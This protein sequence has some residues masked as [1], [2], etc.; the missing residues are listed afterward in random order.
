MTKRDYYDILG[1]KKGASK[2]EIKKAYRK[3]ALKYHPDKNKSAGAEDK[4]KEISE[5]YGVLSDEQKR[6]QYDRFGHAGI[7]S[8]YTQEDIFKNINFD[9]IFGDL[10]F[11]GGFGG[12]FDMFFG[13]MG[14]GRGRSRKKAP[15]R[16]VDLQ[17]R[18][19]ITLEQAAKGFEAKFNLNREET[20]P[21][22]NG[23]GAKSGTSPKSCKGCGGSGQVR[24]QRSTPFGAFTT[25]TTCP[26]CRGEGAVIDIPCTS[27]SGLG[28]RAKTEKIS[29]KIPAGVDTGTHLR[30]GGK[31]NAGERG[32]PPGDLYV[33]INVKPHPVFHRQNSDI[34]LEVP[35]SYS[36]AVLGDEVEVPTLN[37]KVKLKI[38][39]GTQ[40]GTVFRMRGKGVK[41]LN[42]RG[43]GDQ[44]VK[45]TIRVPEKP[46][47]E[48]RIL[49]ERL[50]EIEKNE[51][52][53]EGIFN[54]WKAK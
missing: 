19:S 49:V 22:C 31:G 15:R 42:G 29:L 30:V 1:V 21:T 9:D 40:P 3:L 27:C 13:G 28:K 51:D 34:F 5:A 43:H 6:A 52:K 35:I 4:F 47:Q 11:G 26:K 18:L 8:R 10:G 46:S 17:Y 48:E 38:P 53:K 23:S 50:G 41:H 54:R 24:S 32:G 12:I 7:D 39:A 14:G 2:E 25:V 33:L 45:V 20:C 37:G 44:Q 36:S 16:G